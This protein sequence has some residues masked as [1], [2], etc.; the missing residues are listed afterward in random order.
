MHYAYICRAA[1]KMKIMGQLLLEA[2]DKGYDKAIMV[3]KL[4]AMVQ[5]GEDDARALKKQ[6]TF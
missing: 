5:A 2:R 3:R 4:R 1:E 6:G